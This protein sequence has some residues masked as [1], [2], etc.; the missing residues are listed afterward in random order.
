MSQLGPEKKTEKKKKLKKAKK[1]AKKKVVKGPPKA[2]RVTIKRFVSSQE[3][4]TV[5]ASNL[6]VDELREGLET[7]NLNLVQSETVEPFVFVIDP[8]GKRLAVLHKDGGGGPDHA[9]EVEVH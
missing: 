1:K 6:T 7:G 2:R 8:R 3:D 4:F 9:V 5:E